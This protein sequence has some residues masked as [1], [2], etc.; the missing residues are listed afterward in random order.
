MRKR[1]G[2]SRDWIFVEPVQRKELDS[3]N[4]SFIDVEIE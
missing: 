4:N 2:Q 1:E 3:T